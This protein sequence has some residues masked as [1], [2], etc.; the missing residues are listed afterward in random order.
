V[1][2]SRN[3][4]N[5]ILLKADENCLFNAD[6]PQQNAQKGNNPNIISW[7][8]GQ[9]LF[10]NTELSQVVDDLEHA[11]GIKILLK[12]PDLGKRVV[13]VSFSGESPEAVLNVITSAL[14]LKVYKVGDV[15]Q[16]EGSDN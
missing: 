12:N 16:I 3:P 2:D 5:S 7:E 9:L 10:N 8:T 15:Y 13:T 6:I 4:E 1:F 14:G 11:Y